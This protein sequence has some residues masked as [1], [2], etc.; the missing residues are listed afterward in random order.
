M[1]SQ[2]DS[3]PQVPDAR[4][5]LENFAP[6]RRGPVA[7]LF[8]GAVRGGASTP[9]AVLLAVQT[10]C[11]QRLRWGGATDAPAVLRA[12]QHDREGALAY[13]EYVLHYERL[14]LAERQKLKAER[15]VHF[16]K[17]AMVGKAATAAQLAYLVALGHTGAVA[18]RAE[19]S[20]LIDECLRAQKNPVVEHGA[21][22]KGQTS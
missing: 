9:Q 8:H 22:S 13:A 18:D 11:G 1:V 7:N 5:F 16:V 3:V 17:Q 21:T 12:L 14:P 15:A 6:A 2:P 10:D 20:R 4:A 19:A